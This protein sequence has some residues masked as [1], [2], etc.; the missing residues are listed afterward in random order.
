[1]VESSIVV[2]SPEEQD[3]RKR[4]AEDNQADSSEKSTEVRSPLTPKRPRTAAPVNRQR[5]QRLFGVLMGTLNRFKNESQSTSA[6]DKK[7]QEI[8]AKLHE[9]LEAERKQMEEKA[10]ADRERRQNENAAYTRQQKR[11]YEARQEAHCIE[12]T[13]RLAR[14][15]KTRT[16]PSLYYMPSRLTDAM[17][18]QIDAQEKEAKDARQAYEERRQRRQEQ[19]APEDAEE[20]KQKEGEDK[21]KSD[22]EDEGKPVQL[23]S[24]PP[25]PV[26]ADS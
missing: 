26:V 3:S 9:K 19:Q 18:D 6:I 10:Q 12:Q 17:K 20:R 24:P 14:Y 2:P 8:N 4:T 5:D 15:L 22:K 23:E 1:M 25:G 13:E 11:D 7:R 16:E 21:D